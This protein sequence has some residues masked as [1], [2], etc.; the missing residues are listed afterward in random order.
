MRISAR[1]TLKA[2]VK[3]IIPG[4]VNSEVILEISEG[5]EVTAIIT[6][7]AVQSLNL[8]EGADAYAVVKSTDVMV[9]VD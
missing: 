1:N 8:T 3:K 6:K 5:I 9:A 4:S 7:D 2:K